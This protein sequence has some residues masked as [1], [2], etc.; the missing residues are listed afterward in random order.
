MEAHAQDRI[1]IQARKIEEAAELRAASHAHRAMVQVRQLGQ[2]CGPASY[3]AHDMSSRQRL[4]HV[5]SS[6]Q[7]KFLPS[8]QT[9]SHIEGQRSPKHMQRTA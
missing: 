6:Q 5:L 2:N 7:R 1:T 4:V 8:Q 3:L 9:S